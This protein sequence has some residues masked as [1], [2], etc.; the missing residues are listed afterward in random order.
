MW[1]LLNIL[2]LNLI[3]STN[4]Q[5]VSAGGSP[6]DWFDTVSN[7]F[8]SDKT[9]W[10]PKLQKKWQ[11]NLK[12][13]CSSFLPAILPSQCFHCYN[14]N[15]TDLLITEI[16]PVLGEDQFELCWL[17]QGFTHLVESRVFISRE[18]TYLFCFQRCDLGQSLGILNAVSGR[19]R[20][21]DWKWKSWVD[22]A[23]YIL[24][25]SGEGSPLAHLAHFVVLHILWLRP[26]VATM[27]VTAATERNSTPS[28]RARSCRKSNNPVRVTFIWI[29]WVIGQVICCSECFT[30]ISSLP[31]EPKGSCNVNA[32]VLGINH[33]WW[34]LTGISVPE[35]PSFGTQAGKGKCHV[36]ALTIIWSILT[37]LTFPLHRHMLSPHCPFFPQDKDLSQGQHHLQQAVSVLHG[38]MIQQLFSCSL[39]GQITL[40]S[41]VQVLCSVL[42]LSLVWSQGKC[43]GFFNGAF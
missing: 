34:K 37:K 25:R 15:I 36:L 14:T 17:T 32:A 12:V 38:K 20:Y 11:W 13:S 35:L 29:F 23:G 41:K 4:F 42:T 18:L 10:T 28:K 22:A 27:G 39:G 43:K 8:D 3:I 6:L 7:L 40:R 30:S 26:G 33:W 5:K 31:S 21:A 19:M 16:S 2:F 1:V 24:G 9:W